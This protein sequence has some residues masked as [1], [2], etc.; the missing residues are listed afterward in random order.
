MSNADWRLSRVRWRV[1]RLHGL[2]AKCWEGQVPDP[3]H[4]VG[5]IR[6]EGVSMRH[7]TRAAVAGARFRLTSE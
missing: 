3:V 4:I 6:G 1:V 7:F 5:P 2:T